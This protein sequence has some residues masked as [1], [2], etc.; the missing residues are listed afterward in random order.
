M[1]KELRQLALEALII[2]SP[3]DKRLAVT[4]LC[5]DF[6]SGK[7]KLDSH[8]LFPAVTEDIPGKPDK[9]TLVNPLSVKKRSM[10]SLEGRAALIHALAHIEFNAINLAL[11]AVWRFNNLPETY[12][13]DWLRIAQ[14]ESYHFELLSSYLAGIGYAYGAFEA[15]NSLWEMVEKTKANP[16]ARMALVPR[17]MESRG[18]DALPLIRQRFIQIKDQEMTRILKVILDDEVGHV[19]VGNRWFNYLCKQKDIDPIEIYKQLVID[20]KAPTLKGPFNIEGRKAAGF[21][22]QELVALEITN[23]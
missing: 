18:L 7:V 13:S 9:P 5:R 2:K 10:N 19:Q 21:T 1:E 23:H 12:Y 4:N 11:D 16:L 17:T 8:K 3:A 22:D 6:F 20:Y 14:E 15:H